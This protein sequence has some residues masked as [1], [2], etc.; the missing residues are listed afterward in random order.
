MQSVL[1]TEVVHKLYN[2]KMA[3]LLPSPPHITLYITL[4]EKRRNAIKLYNIIP[5]STRLGGPVHLTRNSS[6]GQV[7][8]TVLSLSVLSSNKTVHWTQHYI[9]FTDIS[10]GARAVKEP[11]HFEVRKSSSQVTRMHFFL[12]KSWRPSKHRPR[13]PFH[14]QNK[15][16][17]AI[18][19]G[20]IFIFCSHYY[21]SKAIRR[22]RQGGARAWARAVDLP[23]R[24]FDLARAA[25]DRGVWRNE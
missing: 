3:F 18:R 2:A 21:R 10:G 6:L 19:Y 25:T 13:T 20:N 5:T 8:V 7:M 15:T 4:V 12:Q 22:A 17:K 14:R 9:F 11:G 24:S 16:N 23:A 1:C